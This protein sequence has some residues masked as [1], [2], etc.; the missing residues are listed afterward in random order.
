MIPPAPGTSGAGVFIG[1]WYNSR[2]VPG[3]ANLAIYQ[4]DDYAA[5]VTVQNA[6]RTPA[7]LTGY[8][9]N[10]QMRLGPADHNP[11][12]V[13]EIAAA[14]TPPNT[15]SLNIPHATTAQL[16]GQYAWDLQL[17]SPGNIITTILAGQANVTLQVTE[18][19]SDA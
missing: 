17:V 18:E 11:Q 15:I 13:V 1:R 9:A 2:R 4:G 14:I 6:D 10:A 5:L 16:S 7:D 3:K 12:V 8:V 19:A